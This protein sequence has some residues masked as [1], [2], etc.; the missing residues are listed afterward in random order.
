MVFLQISKKGRDSQSTF[1]MI[2]WPWWGFLYGAPLLS[3]VKNLR[4]GTW[5]CLKEG[6]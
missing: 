2:V 4:R 5:W 3:K 6:G 1:S